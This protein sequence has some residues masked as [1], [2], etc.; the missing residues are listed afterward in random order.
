MGSSYL[1]FFRSSLQS[2]PLWVTLYIYINTEPKG[3]KFFVEPHVTPGNVYRW[4]NFQN[5]ASNNIRFTK[6]STIHNIFFKS[7]KYWFVFILQCIQR[8]HIHNRNRRWEQSA[9]KVV[10]IFMSTLKTS[11]AWSKSLKNNLTSLKKS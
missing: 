10:Y 3:L 6:I 5:L 4:S 11:L 9:L 8:E 2:H 7:T 1:N